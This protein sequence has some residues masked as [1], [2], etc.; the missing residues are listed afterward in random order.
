MDSKGHARGD[1]A[2]A[3]VC[4]VIHGAVDLHR[5]NRVA[6]KSINGTDSSQWVI[7]YP[8]YWVGWRSGTEG[9]AEELDG[10]PALRTTPVPPN[11]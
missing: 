4:F 10:N 7:A 9:L 2:R 8:S 1:T 5:V 11:L 3:D 6:L